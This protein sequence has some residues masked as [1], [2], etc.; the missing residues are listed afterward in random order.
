MIT[1]KN[2]VFSALL[3]CLYW[4]V[5]QGVVVSLQTD[6]PAEALARDKASRY[7]ETSLPTGPLSISAHFSIHHACS[8]PIVIHHYAI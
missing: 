5:Y 7:S 1:F 3:Q 4:H 8:H 2:V 6:L